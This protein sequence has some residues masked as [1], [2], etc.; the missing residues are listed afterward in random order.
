MLADPL[1]STLVR[2][3]PDDARLYEECRLRHAAV[4]NAYAGV[5]AEMDRLNAK[6]KH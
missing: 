5:K 6:G 4:V 2:L 1:V 3:S